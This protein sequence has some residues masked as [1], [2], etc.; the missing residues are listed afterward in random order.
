L[1]DFEPWIAESL[2]RVHPLP[3]VTADWDDVLERARVRRYRTGP[4]APTRIPRKLMLAFALAVAGVAVLLTGSP[5]DSSPAVLER[6]AAALESDGQILHVVARSV[7]GSGTTYVE[8]WQLP[9]GSLDHVISRTDWNGMGANCV[10]SATQTRC[11][12]RQ[13]NVVDVCQ[14]RPPDPGYPRDYG[15]STGSDFRGSLQ[16]GLASGNARLLGQTTFDGKAVYAVLL[17]VEGRDGRPQ[18][19]D[20]LSNTLYVD[21]QTYLPVAEYAPTDLSTRYFDTFQFLPDTAENRK[22]VELA[23]PA[24]AEVVRH[25]VIVCPPG[26]EGK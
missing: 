25:G 11:W 7:D 9:D 19:V 5:F 26:G 18:F 12:N 24:D 3:P 17:A 2:A 23:A 10:I 1:N 16:R 6:A 20:G 4:I 8:S 15:V 21:R 13:Q 22:A 14:N